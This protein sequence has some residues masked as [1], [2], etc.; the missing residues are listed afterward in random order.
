MYSLNLIL[1]V[2]MNKHQ[3]Q[4]VNIKTGLLHDR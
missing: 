1:V 4:L 3:I 2:R